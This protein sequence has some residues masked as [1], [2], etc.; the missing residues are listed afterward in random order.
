MNL[1]VD[2]GKPFGAYELLFLTCFFFLA[3]LK[4]GLKNEGLVQALEPNSQVELKVTGDSE[5]T[6]GLVAVDKAVYV[7]NSKHKLTQK[8]VRA[9]DFRPGGGLEILAGTPASSAVK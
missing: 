7:L 5:A 2:L 6:V 1:K 8:K 9:Y 4:V 3:Q